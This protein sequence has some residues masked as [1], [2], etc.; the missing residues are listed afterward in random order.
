VHEDTYTKGYLHSV[1]FT[2][3]S[4]MRNIKK[5]IFF[6]TQEEMRHQPLGLQ[7]RLSSLSSP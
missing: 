5:A 3:K 6:G 4:E 2:G 7:K 1:G